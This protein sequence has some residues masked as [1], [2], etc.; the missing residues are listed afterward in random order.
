MNGELQTRQP[1]GLGLQIPL[2]VDDE[3]SISGTRWGSRATLP[4]VAERDS[5]EQGNADLCR[6]HQPRPRAYA[7][8]DTAAALGIESGAISE[9]KE[10]APIAIG[11]QAV[12]EALLGSASMGQGLL[13]GNQRQCDGRSMERVHR[14]S[15]ATGT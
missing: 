10:F 15:E 9:G 2:G 7:D 6:Q 1:Y 4:G 5:D 11:V 12:K 8:R 13:G 3:V 14:K